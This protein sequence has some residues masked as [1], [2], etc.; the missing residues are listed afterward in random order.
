MRSHIS[1]SQG[2]PF[3]FCLQPDT[4][5]PLPDLTLFLT[6]SPEVAA[7][8]GA[9]GAERY[10]NLAM[11]TRVREQFA[12]VGDEV[13]KRHGERWIEVSAEGTLDEVERHIWEAV[14]GVRVSDEMGRLWV[15]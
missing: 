12:L 6:L 15:R 8:R 5:L 4:G 10:E 14:D 1:N 7:Q 11:Q 9:Y 3:D 13:R 2:L